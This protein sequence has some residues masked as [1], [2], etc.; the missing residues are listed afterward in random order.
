MYFQKNV[1]LPRIDRLIPR[2]RARL[3]SPEINLDEINQVLAEYHLQLIDKPYVPPGRGRSN[4]IIIKTDQGKKVLKRYKKTVSDSMIDHEHSI[5]EFLLRDGFPAPKLTPRADG[6]TTTKIDKE[7]F[8]LFD[9][10]DGGIHYHNYFLPP[11]WEK[12]YIIRSAEILAEMHL[13]LEDFIPEGNNPNGFIG[14]DGDRGRNLDWYLNGIESNLEQAQHTAKS[15]QPKALQEIQNQAGKMQDLLPRLER[16]IA[17]AEL[18]VQIIHGDFGPYNILFQGNKVIAVLDFELSRLDWRITD[19]VYA[20]PRFTRTVFGF[21]FKKIQ[22]LI[23]EYRAKNPIQEK[24]LVLVPKIWKYFRI[25]RCI[26]CWSRYYETQQNRWL[27]HAVMNLK[28]ADIMAEFEH[29]F[30]D[31]LDLR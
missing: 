9:F 5:L 2:I 12:E 21:N 1:Y 19:L 13:K 27:D 24:E 4:S 25:K 18:P 15:E 30:L 23:N 31:R 16:E 20:L 7:K 17:A 29:Q 10:I 14:K 3:T 6:E 8:V 28:R 26:V 22:F 11:S